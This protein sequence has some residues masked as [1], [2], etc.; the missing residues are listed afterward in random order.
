V[1]GAE[2][3]PLRE[4]EARTL[5]STKRFSLPQIASALA[6]LGNSKICSLRRARISPL[7]NDP[8]SRKKRPKPRTTNHQQA[9]TS[10]AWKK[11]DNPALPPPLLHTNH[12]HHQ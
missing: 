6:K 8:R 4:E 5:P 12:P 7:F 10:T 1:A 9:I 2:D 11:K 3:L